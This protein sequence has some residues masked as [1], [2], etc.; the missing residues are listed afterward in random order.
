MSPSV[1]CDKSHP[2]DESGLAE[3]L[4]KSAALWVEI[5]DGVRA[6]WESVVEEW[7]YYGAKYGWSLKTLHKKR[8]LFF[9]IPGEGSFMISFVFG[10]KAVAAIEESDLPQA[11]I[12]EVRSAKKYA[13]G[14][15]LRIAVGSSR[16]V[17]HVRKLVAI[18]MTN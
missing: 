12:E 4:G 7:K 3:A 1:F 18:K 8:N 16:D 13:E 11:L 2:P 14:R 6:D 5:R 17:E 15:G 10:D 9:F